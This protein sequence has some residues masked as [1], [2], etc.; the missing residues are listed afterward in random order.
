MPEV[1][2]EFLPP[3]EIRALI[4]STRVADAAARARAA[5]AAAAQ[6]RR[7]AALAA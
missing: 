1:D 7:R 2:R 6:K 5:D 3:L 4:E